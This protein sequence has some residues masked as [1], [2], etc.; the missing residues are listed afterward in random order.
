[1]R[2]ELPH[3]GPLRLPLPPRPMPRVAAPAALRRMPAAA[4]GRRCDVTIN[5][6]APGAGQPFLEKEFGRPVE[7]TARA[8]GHSP[9]GY[10]PVIE[11]LARSHAGIY[12]ALVA[13]LLR[14]GN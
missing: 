13:V 10:A 1:V 5:V 4:I 3:P 6:R 8:A 9:A 12:G 14:S 11:E 7:R 2:R